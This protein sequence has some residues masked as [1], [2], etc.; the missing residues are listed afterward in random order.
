MIKLLAETIIPLL[1][2]AISSMMLKT[3]ILS[4]SLYDVI[5][6]PSQTGQ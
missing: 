4:W 2:T 1:F 6:F 5:M 3:K